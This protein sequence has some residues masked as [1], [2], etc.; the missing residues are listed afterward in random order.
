MRWQ[1]SRTFSRYWCRRSFADLALRRSEGPCGTVRS[2]TPNSLAR[3][4][5]TSQR[6]GT[7]LRL[8]LESR[9]CSPSPRLFV[10]PFDVSRAPTDLRRPQELPTPLYFTPG[11]ICGFFHASSPALNVIACVPP[12]PPLKA[13]ADIVARRSGL[14]NAGYKVS[15]SH[16][17][18][19][20]IKTDAP[21]AFIFDVMREWIKVSPVSMKNVKAGSPTMRLLAKAQTC[22][23]FSCSS[24][25]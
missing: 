8:P 17:C 4:S 22:V 11:R 6:T 20:S 9:A 19:G 7:T 1:V 25:P 5:S 24:I 2:T 12:S 16:A 18:A 21:R 23:N 3:C 13:Q 10:V 15:L 14:L